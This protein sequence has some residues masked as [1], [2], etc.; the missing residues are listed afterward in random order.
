MPTIQFTQAV[1]FTQNS[2]TCWTT[3]MTIDDVVTLTLPKQGVQL[4][5]FKVANRGIVPEQSNKIV[6]YFNNSKWALPPLILATDR[7]IM[8][9]NNGRI[10]CASNQIRVLDGQHRVQAAKDAVSNGKAELGTEQ[11][12][13]VI[14]EVEDLQEQTDLWLDF[15]KSRPIE[16]YWRDAVDNNSPA[17]KAAKTA[18]NGLSKVLKGRT[19]IGKQNLKPNDPELITLTQLKRVT[20]AIAIGFHRIANK[21]SMSGFADNDRQ[22][23][24]TNN[25]VSFFDNFL[26]KCEPHYNTLKNPMDFSTQAVSLK[27]GSNAFDAPVLRLFAHVHARWLNAGNN[28]DDLAQYISEL[29]MSK[30]DTQNF[31]RKNK[32]WQTNPEKYTPFTKPEEKQLWINAGEYITNEAKGV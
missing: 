20:E 32:L 11:I 26:P 22:K 24:L 31:F 8:K 17:T 25:I 12:A 28:A 10:S 7:G 2:R 4:D 14:I 23:E 15:A 16:G 27:T 30:S 21:K 1:K 29:N 5:M 3:T 18:A 13:A 9:T 19:A 6:S